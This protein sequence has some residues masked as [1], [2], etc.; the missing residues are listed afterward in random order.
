MDNISFLENEKNH[1]VS[2]IIDFLFT[3]LNN[4]TIFA[5]DEENYKQFINLVSND[6]QNKEIIKNVLL[7]N[8]K[9]IKDTAWKLHVKYYTE[10]FKIN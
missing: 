9:I 8:G 4:G 2:T 1:S 5:I 6:Y 10:N 3:I 7:N